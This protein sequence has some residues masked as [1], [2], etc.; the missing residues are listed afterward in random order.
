MS[1]NE[2][3]IVGTYSI[4]LL[5]LKESIYCLHYVAGKDNLCLVFNL[6]RGCFSE[7]EARNCIFYF[8]FFQL[9]FKFNLK[10]V[11]AYANDWPISGF[12]VY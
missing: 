8:L 11:F 7:K 9:K 3:I 12:A 5:Q 2:V 10:M 1:R 4:F 6:Y